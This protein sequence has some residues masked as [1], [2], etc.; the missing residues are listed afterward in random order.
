[1]PPCSCPPAS[2]AHLPCPHP[3]PAPTTQRVRLQ[4]WTV[5]LAAKLNR[6]QALKSD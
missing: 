3:P 4:M 6:E 2:R 5:Y 1:V